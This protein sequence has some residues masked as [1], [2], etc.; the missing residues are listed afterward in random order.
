MRALS[1]VVGLLLVLALLSGCSSGD[2]GGGGGEGTTSPG[3]T[4]T[5]GGGGTTPPGQGTTSAP[6]PDPD[7]GA[8]TGSVE[9]SVP[10]GQPPFNVTFLLKGSDPDG[11]P[12]SWTLSFGDGSEDATAAAPAALPATVTHAYAT[13]GL[14]NATYRLSDGARASTFSVLVNATG[15]ASQEVTGTWQ[16]SS[17]GCGG[18]FASWAFGT[19]AAGTAWVEFDVD[20]ATVGRPFHLEF[21][22]SGPATVAG[23]D[24]YSADG[25]TRAGGQFDSA[26]FDGTVPEGA[27]KGLITDCGGVEF[28]FAYRTS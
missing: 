15:G 10:G 9:A 17:V 22:S 25:M 14:F 23:V 2:P 4:T 13:A 24:F 20:A 28:D 7:N 5:R 6:P 18:P 16:A 27:E 8:P 3:A 21:S 12:V 26:P 19:P 1:P 11:D